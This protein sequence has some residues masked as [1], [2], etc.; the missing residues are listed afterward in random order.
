MPHLRTQI[1][2]QVATLLTGLSTT[3]PR[4]H[5]SRMRPQADA[6]LPCLLVTTNAEDIEQSVVGG[7]FQRRLQVI[8][9]GVAK[10]SAAVD[11]VLDQ[12]AFEVEVAM[13]ADRRATLKSIETAFDDDTDK[14]VGRIGMLYE[15]VYSTRAGNPGA[16]A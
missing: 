9:E 6:N 5:Q 15:L 10:A 13:V 12:I 4:V 3:G 8:V 16:S 2:D 7:L 14:P 11:D 1:R